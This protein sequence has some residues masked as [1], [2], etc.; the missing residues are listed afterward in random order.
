MKLA[1]SLLPAAVLLLAASGLSS[2]QDSPATS[3]QLS[4]LKSEVSRLNDQVAQLKAKVDRM[5]S[6][7]SIAVGPQDAADLFLTA[8]ISAAKAGKLAASGE[9]AEAVK[10]YEQASAMLDSLSA[11]YPDW[12]PPIVVYRQ[13]KIAEALQRL[14]Q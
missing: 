4:E 14:R 7:T 3:Q 10:T 1:T 2:G 12:K 9:I 5:K 11:T 13:R 8:F 6:G